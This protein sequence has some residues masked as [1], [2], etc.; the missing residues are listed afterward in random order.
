MKRLAALLMC[1]SLIVVLAACQESGK[2]TG[3]TISLDNGSVELG[4]THTDCEG[5]SVQVANVVLNEEETVLEIT[6]SNETL[7]SVT[8]G[9]SYVIEKEENGEW[10]NCAVRDDIAFISIGYELK[11]GMDYT[12]KYDLNDTYSIAEDGKYR[13]RS[14]CFVYNNGLGGE[15]SDCTV[16]AEFTVTSDNASSS[17]GTTEMGSLESFSFSLTWDCFGISSYDSVTGK[18]VKTKDA[19][20]PEDYITTYRLTDEQKKQIYDLITDL[21]ITSYPDFY[22]PHA[23]SLG[24]DPSMTLVLSVQTDTLQKTVT[25]KE[26]A[27]TY[28]A[29]NEKGQ[30][31]RS[32]CK[33]IRDILVETEAW[34]ALPEYEFFYD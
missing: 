32:V 16:W 33:A 6:W 11:P 21:N 25:A 28:E 24:S 14:D 20:N 2:E 3:G 29:E 4:E 27:L 9:A 10:I 26:I 30:E 31:F 18:L 13:F 1:L 23:N 34:K 17:E 7:F 19:T 8:Y 12:R 22:D 5:V 15:S